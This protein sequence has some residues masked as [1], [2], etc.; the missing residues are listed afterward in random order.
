MIT[1]QS[2]DGSDVGD[3]AAEL[4]AQLAEAPGLA[5]RVQSEPAWRTAPAGLIELTA[6]AWLNAP[7][8]RL[9]KLEASLAPAQLDALLQAPLGTISESLNPMTSALDS[10]D[11][12]A[13]GSVL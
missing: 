10:R 13:L 5:K 9:L 1:L 12:P 11:P 3:L 7:P 2:S 6:N 4:A 8:E